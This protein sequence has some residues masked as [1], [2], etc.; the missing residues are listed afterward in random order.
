MSEKEYGFSINMRKAKY[1]FGCHKFYLNEQV[2]KFNGSRD[3]KLWT[4]K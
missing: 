1:P 4:K 2:E 3:A